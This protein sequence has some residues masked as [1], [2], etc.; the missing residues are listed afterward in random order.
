LKDIG[1]I[2]RLGVTGTAVNQRGE[3]DRKGQKKANRRRP[4]AQP[5][6]AP[7]P[8]SQLVSSRIFDRGPLA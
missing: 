2:I 5:M 1:Q 7:I 4:L 6:A 3:R 8:A